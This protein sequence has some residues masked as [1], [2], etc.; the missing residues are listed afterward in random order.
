MFRIE[1]IGEDDVTV[2]LTL[3]GRITAEGIAVLEDACARVLHG[4]KRLILDFAGVTFID[5]D[6]VAALGKMRGERVRC[7]NC[8]PFIEDVL[9]WTRNG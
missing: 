3:E 9:G 5:R 6:G 1:T 4:P 7:V 8:C 2:T